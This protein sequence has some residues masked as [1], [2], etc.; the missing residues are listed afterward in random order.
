MALAPSQQHTV[1][2]HR[3]WVTRWLTVV[4][5]SAR[6]CLQ[7]VVARPGANSAVVHHKTLSDRA[8]VRKVV[9]VGE[10]LDPDDT[11]RVVREHVPLEDVLAPHAG[12][13]Q[14]RCGGPRA[15]HAPRPALTRDVG[16]DKG[17]PDHI[18]CPARL[19]GA[20]DDRGRDATTV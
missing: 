11:R 8:V 13:A 16:L 19:T 9:R 12:A 6:P 17:T 2:G 1:P 10:L 15:T 18:A 3:G 5:A 7:R 4:D 20:Y 14:A